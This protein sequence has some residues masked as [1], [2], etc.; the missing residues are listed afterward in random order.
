MTEKEKNLFEIIATFLEGEYGY[1]PE[2]Y[3]KDLQ[4][5]I[6]EDC[7][8]LANSEFGSITEFAAS[9]FYVPSEMAIIKYVFAFEYNESFEEKLFF[10]DKEEFA[11]YLLNVSFDGLL[12]PNIEEEKLVEIVKS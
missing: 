5:E 4:R 1:E 11:Q 9:T 3:E 8:S 6:K 12:E 10:K 7:V 2:E